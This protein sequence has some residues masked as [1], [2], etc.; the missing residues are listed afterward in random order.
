MGDPIQPLQHRDV[1]Q[2]IA[3]HHDHIRQLAGRQ[4]A[5]LIAEAEELGRR[6]RRRLNRLVRGEAALDQLLQL[7]GVLAVVDEEPGIAAGGDHHPGRV[8]ALQAAPFGVVGRLQ[9]A[10]TPLGD[11]ELLAGIGEVAAVDDQRRHVSG[12]PLQH[13][14]DGAVGQPV[15]VLDGIDA[16]R[17]GRFDRGSASRVRGH[18]QPEPVCFGASRLHFGERHLRHVRRVRVEHGADVAVDLDEVDV[19][20][21]HLAHGSPE[22]VQRVA[23]ADAAG[24]RHVIGERAPV[25]VAAGDA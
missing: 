20:L 1:R 19:A 3:G 8:G 15:A 17:E 7:A 18:L 6:T 5:N 21:G 24:E 10:P 13:Q 23:D 22:L 4:R 11:A 25:H 2:R 16:G 14:L 12:V 9:P